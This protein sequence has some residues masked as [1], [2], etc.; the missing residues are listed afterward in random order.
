MNKKPQNLYYPK[1]CFP[2]RDELCEIVSSFWVWF[3]K[4]SGPNSSSHIPVFIPAMSVRDIWSLCE[5]Y[6]NWPGA[7]KWCTLVCSWGLQAYFFDC[8]SHCLFSQD[9]INVFGHDPLLYFPVFSRLWR[10][11]IFWKKKQQ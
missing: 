2:W 6:Q 4:G 8:V 1:G 10:W 3:S 5:S 9:I 7:E 11:I